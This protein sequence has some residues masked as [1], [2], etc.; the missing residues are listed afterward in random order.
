MGSI[1]QTRICK[2]CNQEKPLEVFAKS[3][4]YIQ[5]ECKSCQLNRTR[6]HKSDNK[7]KSIEYKG[8][9]CIDCSYQGNPA[10]YDFHHLD[11]R[12]KDKKPNVLMGCTWEKIKKELDKCVLLCANCHRIR[13]HKN[14]Q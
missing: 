14:G 7:I 4:N 2:K 5:H 8:G 10:V 1:N 12:E 9:K 3:K 6:K 13:H 11:T